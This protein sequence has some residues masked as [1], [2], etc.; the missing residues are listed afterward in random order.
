MV[1]AAQKTECL[2]RW[3]FNLILRRLRTGRAVGRERM[4]RQG[5]GRGGGGAGE[6]GLERWGFGDQMRGAGEGGSGV[7]RVRRDERS[8]GHER[9]YDLY[10]G[11]N[12]CPP[13]FC[14]SVVRP[15]PLMSRAVYLYCYTYSLPR[16]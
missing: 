5:G 10:D 8:G 12:P 4:W 16:I 7:E 9:V 2:E 11:G 3:V 13:P 6:R 14:D 1:S 15:M